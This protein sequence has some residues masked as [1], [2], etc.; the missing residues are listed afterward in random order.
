MVN[1]IARNCILVPNCLYRVTIPNAILRLHVKWLAIYHMSCSGHQSESTGSSP[2]WQAHCYESSREKVFSFRWYDLGKVSLTQL[3]SYEV[4][5]V[6]A[7]VYVQLNYVH[8]M[9]L[10]Q[11][12]WGW[13]AK[14]WWR[15]RLSNRRHATPPPP[16]ALWWHELR[17]RQRR[18]QRIGK[19]QN[20]IIT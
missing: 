2:P 12:T 5:Y 20:K 6:H 11:W 3:R 19:L 17:C 14:W 1:I 8:Y 16:S 4:V 9:L 13:W 10:L 15:G 7:H 18:R